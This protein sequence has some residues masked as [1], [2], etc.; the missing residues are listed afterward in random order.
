MVS[1]TSGVPIFSTVEIQMDAGIYAVAPLHDSLEDVERC[2]L[3]AFFQ[4]VHGFA[5]LS[6]E[7]HD[8]LLIHI[9]VLFVLCVIHFGQVDDLSSIYCLRGFPL[10]LPAF[11]AGGLYLRRTII[12]KKIVFDTDN[13]VSRIPF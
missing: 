1:P 5:D 2:D 7:R 10:R 6:F 13:V 9:F 3:S 12:A 11:T 4:R 8:F